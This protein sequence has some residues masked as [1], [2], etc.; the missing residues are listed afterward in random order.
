MKASV[1]INERRAQK[2]CLL[3]LETYHTPFGGQ[4]DQ[5]WSPGQG[6]IGI[7]IFLAHLASFNAGGSDVDRHLVFHQIR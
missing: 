7:E 3:P 6:H 1:V 2:A 5:F 4:F